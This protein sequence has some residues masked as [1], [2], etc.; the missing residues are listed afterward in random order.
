VGFAWGEYRGKR[1]TVQDR[2]RI[3]ALRSVQTATFGPRRTGLAWWQS[4]ATNDQETR[5]RA[6]WRTGVPRLN[7]TIELF[8]APHHK[9]FAANPEERA[10]QTAAYQPK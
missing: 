5:V 10:E 6:S 9:D 2:E 7:A 3:D 4:V 1:L 8:S